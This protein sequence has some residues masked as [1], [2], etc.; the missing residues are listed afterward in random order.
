MKHSI[1]V[2]RAHGTVPR[3]IESDAP[4]RLDVDDTGALIVSLKHGEMLAVF[5]AGQW[6]SADRAPVTTEDDD[7]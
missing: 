6:T 4:L 2:N 7:E 1:T 5:A 3:I